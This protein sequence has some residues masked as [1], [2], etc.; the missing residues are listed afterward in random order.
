MEDDK[1][2]QTLVKKILLKKGYAVDVAENGQEAAEAVK[3]IHYDLILMDIY[4]PIMDG[5]EATKKIRQWEDRHKLERCPIIALTAHAIKG[6]RDQCL[7]NGMDDYITKPVRKKL[8]FETINNWLEPS[9]AVLVVDDS[10]V[11]R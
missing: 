10:S 4:M 5:F 6:Y 7:E 11:N 3:K 2:N 1:D 8:M 9:P